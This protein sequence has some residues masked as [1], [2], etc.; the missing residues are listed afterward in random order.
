MHQL[1]FA[2]V[3]EIQENKKRKKNTTK[4][5]KQKVCSVGGSNFRPWD[6]ETHALPTEPTEL[7]AMKRR[8]TAYVPARGNCAFG[9][10]LI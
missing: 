10:E 9:F 7:P 1:N 2:L 8:W 3:K 4:N 6:Y 5:K